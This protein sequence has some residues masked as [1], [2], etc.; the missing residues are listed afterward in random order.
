MP[1]LPT[2]QP[3]CSAPRRS[4]RLIRLEA[5][6]RSSPND[7]SQLFSPWHIFRLL[8]RLSASPIRAAAS[9]CI[10]PYKVKEHRPHYFFLGPSE[11]LTEPQPPHSNSAKTQKTVFD[12]SKSLKY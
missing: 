10:D 3:H 9:T 8:S 1:S 11:R 12:E 5:M 2:G 4:T 6:P 7:S